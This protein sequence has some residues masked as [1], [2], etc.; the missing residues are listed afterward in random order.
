MEK[1]K[2]YREPSPM[3]IISLDMAKSQLGQ[4]EH[5]KRNNRGPM[6]D[7]YLA[8]VGLNPGY[9]WCQ[10]FVNWCYEQAAKQLMEP[11]PVIN[12]GGV[13]DCWNRTSMNRKLMRSEIL[14]RPQLILPG[15]QFIMLMSKGTGH[16]GIVE[17]AERVSSTWWLHT[18]DGNTD[19]HGGREGYEVARKKRKL[20][21]AT[22]AGI[23]RY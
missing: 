1:T 17:Y 20:V 23:I 13:H 14:A 15:D 3:A 2:L 5:P 22:I 16:T 10:A 11:E 8:A 9:P 21:T 18:I 7:K 6:V 4:E 19:E 12:T